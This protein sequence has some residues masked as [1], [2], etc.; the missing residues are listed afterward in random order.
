MVRNAKGRIPIL[1]KKINQATGKASHQLTGFNELSWGSRCSNY[2]KSAKKLSVSRFEEI[3]SLAAEYTKVN[4]NF[5]DDDIIEIPDD[6]DDIRA[7]IVDHS[8][9]SEGEI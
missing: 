2:V 3:I 8:S 5:E 6:D 4:Q 1:P 7:N 9:S